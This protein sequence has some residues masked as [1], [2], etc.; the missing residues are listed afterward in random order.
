MRK[1]SA[2]TGILPQLNGSSAT[3]LRRR[4]PLDKSGPAMFRKLERKKPSD[5]KVEVAAPVV[6]IYEDGLQKKDE[7]ALERGEND[8]NRLSKPDTRRVL[9]NKNSDDK[10]NKFAGFRSGSRVVPCQEEKSETT[11]EVS[12]PTEGLHQNH[13]ECEDLSLIRK[14]LV[15][16]EN[17]QSSLLELLQVS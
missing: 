7:K 10:M 15:Q 12:N 9:F 6:R 16:I 3:T 14:Q 8:K 17:Q 11:V 2:P 13:K 4:G 5:L 1:K